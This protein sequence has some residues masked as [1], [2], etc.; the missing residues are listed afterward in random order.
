MKKKNETSLHLYSFR[1]FFK[2][3]NHTGVGHFKIIDL[4]LKYQFKKIHDT[5]SNPFQSLSLNT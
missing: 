4:A 1:R 2:F 5:L 3:S